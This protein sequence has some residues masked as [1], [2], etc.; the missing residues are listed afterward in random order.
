MLVFGGVA[1]IG[2]FLITAVQNGS[3]QIPSAPFYADKTPAEFLARSVAEINRLDPL[4]DVAVMTG[5][6]VDHGNPAEY[7]HLRRLLAPLAMPI[8]VIPGNHDV[9]YFLPPPPLF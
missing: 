1:M 6:L 8:F 2:S 5:D 3:R 4:P 7:E 9:G